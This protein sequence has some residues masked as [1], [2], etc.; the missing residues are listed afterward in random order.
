MFYE[1]LIVLNDELL[2]AINYIIK[3]YEKGLSL[4]KLDIT[5]PE[6]TKLGLTVREYHI[7]YGRGY[8]GG[9]YTYCKDIDTSERIP[10]TKYH[11]LV[12]VNKKNSLM[13]PLIHFE[14][15]EGIEKTLNNLTELY[16][17]YE[18]DGMF[19]CPYFYD[20]FPYLKTF[21]DYLNNYRAKNYSATV[22][23]EVIRQAI[24]V[25][26]QSTVQSDLTL[27]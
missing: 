1:N 20:K 16:V 17:E 11:F 2:R 21:F 22:S 26:L 15:Y 12:V 7:E 9:D 19:Y 6:H 10:E 13:I 27:N 5:I 8:C 4:K 14:S 18:D 25:T 3:Q 24:E 23:K